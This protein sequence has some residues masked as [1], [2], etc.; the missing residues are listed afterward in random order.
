MFQVRCMM[1]CLV[2]CLS[3]WSKTVAQE[4]VHAPQAAPPLAEYWEAIYLQGSHVGHAHGLYRTVRPDLIQSNEELTLSLNRF[5]QLLRMHFSFSMLESKEGKI[6]KFTIKQS[7]GRDDELV[8]TGVVDQNQVTI[9]KTQGSQPPVT[10]V[11]PW[12]D[13]AL[14][15]YAMEQL[16]LLDR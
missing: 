11:D 12:N 1:G 8:R 7:M 14:G 9:T 16:S 10:K 2:L 5:N 13:S 4:K 6:Q 3:N 15:L